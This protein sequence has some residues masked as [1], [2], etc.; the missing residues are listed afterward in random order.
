MSYLEFCTGNISPCSFILG[1]AFHCPL[2][3][4][5]SWFTPMIAQVQATAHVSCQGLLCKC[6]YCKSKAR[7]IHCL[8]CRK[9]DAMLIA[10]AK[11]LK[12]EGSISSSSFYGSGI[13]E[14]LHSFREVEFL[15]GYSKTLWMG[16]QNLKTLFIS[17]WT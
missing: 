12:H 5:F 7:E 10:L 3:P 16:R 14:H 2:K 9:V 8:L 13:W 1:Q 4:P 6:G 17:G 11:I 15:R